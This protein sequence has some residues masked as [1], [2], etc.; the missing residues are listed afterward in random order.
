MFRGDIMRKG[1]QGIYGIAFAIVLI[2]IWAAFNPLI[3]SII[4]YA[5]TYLVPGSMEALITP[6]INGL[7]PVVIVGYVWITA[8]IRR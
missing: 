3:E 6:F 1:Q 8:G 2:T 7:I 5:M 4:T